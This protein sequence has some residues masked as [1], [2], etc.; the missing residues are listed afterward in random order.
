MSENKEYLPFP[1]GTQIGRYYVVSC[2]GH[3]AFGAI[4]SCS[5]VNDPSVKLALKCEINSEKR[6]I[7]RREV[8]IHRALN[9]SPYFPELFD[10]D[11]TDSFHFLVMELLGPTITQM[12]NTMKSK[13]FSAPTTIKIGI[14]MLRCVEQMHERGILHRDLKPGNFLVRPHGTYPIVLI[15]FGLCRR[16]IDP[17]THELLEPRVKPGFV[18]TNAYAS[19]NAHLGK[20]LGRRDDLF[21]WF[22]SL[23]KIHTGRLPWATNL[24]KNDTHQAKL[25]SNM[26]HF[27]STLPIQYFSIYQYIRQLHRADKPD[28]SLIYSFLNQILIELGC[29][30]ND[31]FDWMRMKKDNFS[32]ISSI[33]LEFDSHE[34]PKPFSQLPEPILPNKPNALSEEPEPVKQVDV[35]CAAGCN[36]L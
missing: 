28:Y 36:L 3:G 29:S 13:Q 15:D 32:K 10:V 19:L 2:A 8:E 33:P 17:E 30:L 18:G 7:L 21:S 4:Y 14:E 34:R 31:P 12:R 5:L 16:F 24:D 20:E 11:H 6:H 1:P 9:N 22:F 26:E 27:C 23:L 35:S 25:H